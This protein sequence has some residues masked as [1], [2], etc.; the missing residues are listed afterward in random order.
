M[1]DHT[2]LENL[3]TEAN[4][5]PLSTCKTIARRGSMESE[6]YYGRRGRR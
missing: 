2:T 6:S 5:A 3:R 4:R 1:T